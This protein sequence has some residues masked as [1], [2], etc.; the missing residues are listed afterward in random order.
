MAV[1]PTY[2]IDSNNTGLRIA[3]EECL[4]QLPVSPVWFPAEPNSY[5]DFGPSI[6]TVARNPINPSRQRKKGVVTD[7]DA[8]GGFNQDLTQDNTTRF[9]QGFFFADAREPF[10]TRPLNG[11][12][13]PV[14][15]VDTT[16]GYAAAIGAGK[17]VVGDIIQAIG[18]GS[19]ANNGPKV[20]T[21]ADADSVNAAGL[22]A[23]A[24]P[25]AG[26]M[27]HIVGK[28]LASGDISIVMNG[29]L[30]RLTSAA[31]N[32]ITL[33]PDLFPGRWLF[34]GGDGANSRFANNVGFARVSAIAAGYLEFDKVSWAAPVN[35]AGAGKTIQ[36]FDGLVIRNEPDPLNIKRRTY[37]LERTLGQDADGTMAEYLVGA[38]ANELT[39]NM[40]QADKVNIDLGYVACDGTTR[41]GLE[42]LKAGTRPNP[43]GS[44]TAFNTSNNFKRIKLSSV[45]PGVAAPAPLFAFATDLSLTIN[46]NVSPNKA[47]GTLGAFDTSAGTFEVG[48]EITAYFASVAATR[49]VRNNADITIDIIMVKENAGL[50]FDVPLLSLGNGRLGIE[51]DQAVTVPLETNAAESVFGHTLLFQSFGYLPDVANPTEI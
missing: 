51:Q 9:L 15:A 25:P 50:L 31:N 1:C 43:E 28:Q 42:G 32:M 6:T 35:E 8:T 41:T 18:F 13:I 26:A 2:K 47:V 29:G 22:V 27:F 33:F 4:K 38:V 5:S 10:S 16:D 17:V 39:I 3:E 45:I 34:I 12:A 20:V 46:N 7:L 14:T 11:A 40:P 21:A 36:V 49:A 30:V 19:V 44:D 37:Q 48:G 23:E 24:A